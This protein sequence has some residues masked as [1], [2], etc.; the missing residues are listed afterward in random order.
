M[1]IWNGFRREMFEF[2]GRTSYI[3]FPKE[4]EAGRNWAIK[5]EYWDA[6]PGTEIA[7]VEAGFHLLYMTNH[8]RWATP[9]D[10]HA[11]ARFVDYVAKTYGL[12]DKCVPVGM[13]CGGAHAVQF[14]GY[15]PEKVACLYIDAPV[16]NFC[17]C[18]GYIGGEDRLN[19]ALEREFYNAYPGV[20]LYDLPS[21]PHH[22]IHQGRTLIEHRI[23]LVMLYGTKDLTVDYGKNGALLEMLYREHDVP[24]MI[25]PRGVDQGH[26]PH[27]LED[28]TPVVAFIQKHV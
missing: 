13:S 12:R 25:E 17:D 20:R 15:H 23:P 8:N 1:D 11:R 3:V 18:P 5:T 19:G 6:F 16:L 9:E 26:H 27:G 2:E 10:C 28:P 24:F 22:P 14:A 4:P 21:F 7:L